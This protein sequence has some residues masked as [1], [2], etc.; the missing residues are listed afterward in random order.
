MICLPKIIHLISD[1]SLGGV[2]K[3]LAIFDSDIL[4][5]KFASK[6]MPIKSEWKIAPSLDADVIMTHFS[7]S[8]ANLPFLYSLRKRNPCAKII[9]MEHS[10]SPEWEAHNVPEPHRFHQMLKL[11]YARFDKIICVSKTQLAWVLAVGAAKSHK[12]HVI[13]PWSDIDPLLRLQ[14]PTFAM[15]RPL[16]IGSFGRLVKEKGFEDLIQSFLKIPS[17]NDISLLIGGY[18]P[19]E[20]RLTDLARGD[21]R[22]KFYGMVENVANFVQ[23]CDI[24]AVP[25]YFE[26]FGLVATEGR[27]AARPLLVSPVGA[28]IEQMGNGGQVIDFQ[29]HHKAS[30]ILANL[31]RLPLAKMSADGRKSCETLRMQRV[32]NWSQF[33]NLI[34]FEERLLSKAA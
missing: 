32:A 9:H 8:W 13:N 18:G 2:T 27:A 17:G 20:Q 4:R 10:Y 14:P 30:Q 24:I 34:L 3:N 31:N 19:D 25:S 11:S 23:L 29:N 16:T 1:L 7:P 12:L 6:I 22:I 15:G 5:F 28:L 21:P 33:L 26:T